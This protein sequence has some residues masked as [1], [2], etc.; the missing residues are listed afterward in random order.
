VFGKRKAES[1]ESPELADVEQALKDFDKARSKVERLERKRNRESNDLARR[2]RLRGA[3]AA[4]ILIVLLIAIPPFRYPLDG[5]VTS[6]FFFRQRPESRLFFDIEMHRGLDLAAPT[7]TPVRAARSGRVVER[8]VGPGFGNYVVLRH[9]LGMTTVYAHLSQVSV[10]QG[11]I[12]WRAR[13]IGEVGATGRA[14]G[15]HLHFELRAG[16]RSYPPGLFLLFHDLRKAIL[17]F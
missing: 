8:G 6:G 9:P 2:L 17:R 1:G 15:P 5:V 4:A 11:A 7:G 10:R 3:G 16:T 14:T 12:V 13:K